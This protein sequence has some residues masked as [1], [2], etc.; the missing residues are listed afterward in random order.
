M[1]VLRALELVVEVA[2]G[3]RVDLEVVV[4]REHSRLRCGGQSRN[5]ESHDH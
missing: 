5:G 4:D 2:L 3:D 1:V